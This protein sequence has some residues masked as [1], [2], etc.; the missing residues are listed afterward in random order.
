M[1][2][3]FF[4]VSASEWIQFHSGYQGLYA[5]LISGSSLETLDQTL[6]Q[7]ILRMVGILPIAK[8][9]VFKKPVFAA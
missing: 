5:I 2:S 1:N 4:E 3:I 9:R 8:A 6:T 7:A